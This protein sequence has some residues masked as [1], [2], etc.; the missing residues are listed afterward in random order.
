MKRLT[1]LLTF[2]FTLMVSLLPACNGLDDNF[3][4]NPNHRLSFSADTLTFDTIFSTIGSTTRQ[5][6]IYNPNDKPLNIQSVMLAGAGTSGFRINVDGKKGDQFDNISILAKDS[7]Y[8]FVEVTVNPNGKNQPLLIEDSVI[9]QTN[10]VTQS[11]LLQAYGQDVH[12]YKGGTF[13]NKDTRFTAE[14]PYLIYDSLI[15]GKGTTLS[16]DKGATLYMHD[17]AKVIVNGTLTAVGTQEAPITF[18]G[19]RLDFIL[20]D[21]LPYDR[22]PTQWGGIFIQ[23]ESFN[24]LL[25]QVIIRNGTT[26]VNCQTSTPDQKKITIANSQITNMGAGNLFTATNCF[27]E[28]YNTEFSNASGG[29]V[30]LLGGKYQFTHCTLANHIQ[31]VKKNEPPTPCLVLSNFLPDKDKKKTPYALTQAT[32]DNCIIDGGSSAGSKPLMGELGLS[33]VD[34]VAF[35]Y[36][37]NHCVMKTVGSNNADFTNVLFIKQSPSYQMLGGEKNKYRFDF[38][39]DS[40]TTV[41]VGKADPAITAKYPTDRY[42]VSRLSATGPAIGAYEF[43]PKETGKK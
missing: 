36:H 30:V 7:M 12:L 14:R 21:L 39:P 27:I 38:R 18:R 1:V 20:N 17:K 16:I 29:I 37:F 10:S 19:D 35:N 24:N 25:D 42:G 5:F 32:F 4:T 31:L 15:V 9:F 34:N 43:V 26:G 41:G 33:S 3:S 13:L 28:A 22:T 11:V 23:S 2:I 6:M 40:A 8:V